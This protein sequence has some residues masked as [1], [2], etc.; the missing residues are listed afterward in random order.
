MS[1]TDLASNQ[2]L[3]EIKRW[4][5]PRS[6]GWTARLLN[7]AADD[8]NISAIVAIGSAVRSGVRSTDLDLVL[9]CTEP[10]AVHVKPPLEIDLRKYRF[11]ELENEVASGD[12][13]LGWAVKFGRGL[14]Q[15]DGCWD[16]F[17]GRWHNNVPLPSVGVATQRAQ[18]TL[19]R[20]RKVLEVGDTEAAEE[21]A[22]SYATHLARAELLKHGVYP[23]SR[24]E[25]PGQLRTIGAD[26]AADGLAQLIDRSAEHSEQ[27]ATLAATRRLTSACSR[28]SPAPSSGRR[29]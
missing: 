11:S 4:P 25:L 26:D 28:R 19:D 18:S 2:A 27:I 12:D 14:F 16:A 23:A 1:R 5:T 7:Q 15:R 29:G 22:L 3:T 10:S 20:L 24:P 13:V 8:N 21:Q 17:V 6:K 9:I